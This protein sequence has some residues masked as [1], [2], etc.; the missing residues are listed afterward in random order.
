MHVLGTKGWSDDYVPYYLHDRQIRISVRLWLRVKPI[1]DAYVIYQSDWRKVLTYARNFGIRS[2]LKKVVSRRSE[3]TRN[4]KCL[5][6]GWGQVTEIGSAV[7]REDLRP[8]QNVWFVAPFHPQCVDEVCL[9]HELVRPLPTE[10]VGWDSAFVFT[11]D[12]SAADFDWDKVAGWSEWSG[13]CLDQ[14]LLENVF[15]RLAP[16]ILNRQSLPGLTA[17]PATS[18]KTTPPAISNLAQCGSRKQAVMFGMGQYAKTAVAPR[19]SKYLDIACWHEIDPTQIG[20][21]SE[22]HSDLRTSMVPEAG[23]HYD[24]YL[25]AGYHHTHA[26]IAIA[27]LS[28]GADVVVEKPLATTIAQLDALVAELSRAKGR[29]FAGFHKRYNPLNELLRQDLNISSGSNPVS[30]HSIVFEIPLPKNHWYLWPNSRGRIVCN[31][32]HWI[33]HFLY[34]NN[35]SPPRRIDSRRAANGDVTVLMDLENG[36]S[37]S[38]TITD[39]GS[40]RLGVREQTSITLGDRTATI[41]DD[42]KYRAESSTRILR[43]ASVKRYVATDIMYKTIGERILSGAPGDSMASVDVSTRAM[44]VA[45]DGIV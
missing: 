33:D 40:S 38:V 12:Y 27:G 34:L 13:R 45:E 4:L 36:A 42:R 30:Y 23:E 29:F 32:C 8:G 17:L 16:T 24:V 10:P 43:K 20:P 5:A 6:I 19:I 35:F 26:P 7:N 11:G 25:I 37:F 28:A 14:Q 3:R 9:S 21:R 31:G 44:L 15:H 1:Q 41:E 22:R 39:H 18:E 2:T